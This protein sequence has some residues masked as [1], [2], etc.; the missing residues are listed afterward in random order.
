MVSNIMLTLV[1]SAGV[2]VVYYLVPRRFRQWLLLLASVLFYVSAGPW[3]LALSGGSALWSFYT[4]VKIEQAETKEKKKVWL[5]AGILPILGVLFVYKYFN[6]FVGSVAA[7]LALAGLG[8]SA[9]V[10]SLAVPM[11]I[12]YYTFKMISFLADIYLGKRGAERGLEGCGAYLT[13]ILFFPQILSGPIERSEHFIE[14]LHEGP[15]YHAELFSVGLQRIVLG[16]FK[17]IVIANRLA[18]YV[19][20]VFGAPESYPGLA[21]VM[22]AFFYSFQLYCDFSGYSDIAIGMAN[23][24]GIDSGQNFDC[25]YFS[26]G[27]KEFWSRWHISLS[28]WLKDYIYIPLGGNRVS[29]VRHRLNVLATFLVSGLW[30][31]ANWSFVIWGGMHGLWNIISTKKEESVPLA[32]R[33]LETLITFCGVTLAWVF[34]R[35]ESFGKALGFLTYAVTCFSLS[36]VDIQNSILPFTGDNTC[37]AYFLTACGF[38]FLLFLYERGQVYGKKEK[39]E[40][41]VLSSAWLAVMLVSVVLF[42]VFGAS[43]FLYAN[44]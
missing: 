23:V 25:P 43:G 5:W 30:H 40:G 8:G 21:C 39:R 6:F 37:A 2:A 44:F 32:R 1:F 41:M 20:A 29:P 22:A 36:Y 34:F 12:S 17:K 38:L 28:G 16:L 19:D 35:A 31:G 27:I 7:L 13:Y 11:G 26:R 10:L 9:P 18:G 15:T 4:G 3:L 42:G 24:L 33:V 14:Q